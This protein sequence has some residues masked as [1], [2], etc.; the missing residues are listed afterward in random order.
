[1]HE[2]AMMSRQ[3][4]DFCS[5]LRIYL[6]HLAQEKKDSELGLGSSALALMDHT[7]T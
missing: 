7:A 5:V 4:G 1:M 2:T 3:Q 6:H